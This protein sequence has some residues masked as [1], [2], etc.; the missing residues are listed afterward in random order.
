[1]YQ[2]QTECCRNMTSMAEDKARCVERCTDRMQRIQQYLQNELQDFQVT[3]NIQLQLLD[4]SRWPKEKVL[5]LK[6]IFKDIVIMICKTGWNQKQS[7]TNL[8]NRVLLLYSDKSLLTQ[9]WWV[10]K[11]KEE[12]LNTCMMSWLS[13]LNHIG[14]QASSYFWHDLLFILQNRLQRCAMVCQD[15]AKEKITPNTTSVQ[16]QQLQGEMETCCIKCVDEHVGKLKPMY[17]KM[18]G[19]IDKQNI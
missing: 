19:N 12:N 4:F 6:T 13:I 3:E 7:N 8:T 2:C 18:V 5:V 10:F 16:Q 15:N 9:T 11:C 17:S 14:C 1:M